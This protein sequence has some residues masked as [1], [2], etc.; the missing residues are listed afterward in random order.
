MMD[1]DVRPLERRDTAAVYDAI[2]ESQAEVGRWM[3]W[4]REDYSLED[5]VA[6]IEAALEG[7]DDGSA[8]QFGIFDP[9]GRCLGACG[10]SGIDR[11]ARY[12][13]LGY[14]VRSQAAGRGLAAEAARR[15]ID[16]A[17]TYT[18]IERI[19]I[20]AA[21]ENRRSQRVAEKVGAVREGVLRSR[22]CVMDE[23]Q[24]AVMYSVVRKDRRSG[25]SAWL[26]RG[27]ATA[28]RVA[29]ILEFK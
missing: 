19:E 16:W 24:D 8:Y 23:F 11:E 15:V 20:I 21:V 13:N 6:W 12:A 5:T 22:L 7:R 28:G 26:D 18:D 14:W 1:I 3:D 4:C 29:K 27:R 2:I 25:V 17:F 9:E 10:L